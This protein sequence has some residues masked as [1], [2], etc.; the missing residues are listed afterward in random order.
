MTELIVCLTLPKLMYDMSQQSRKT[1]I[2][3]A[4]N[5]HEGAAFV[6]IISHVGVEQAGE[7][8][9]R[10]RTS[11]PETPDVFKNSFIRM[12]VALVTAIREARMKGI[13]LTSASRDNWSCVNVYGSG[14][15][16]SGKVSLVSW[17]RRRRR[18]FM[19]GS[20][21]FEALEE[22]FATGVNR[23]LEDALVLVGTEATTGRIRQ[24]RNE[25]ARKTYAW[26]AQHGVSFWH[27]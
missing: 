7:N 27:A 2:R 3:V 6:F 25:R 18:S 17:R 9:R 21:G 15:L 26:T 12:S 5:I 16:L 4:P 13:F 8:A 1:W 24:L 23:S 10:M 14:N 19:D 20:T 22:R 11:V